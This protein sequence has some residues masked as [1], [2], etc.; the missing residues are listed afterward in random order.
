MDKFLEVSLEQILV[1]FLR[2][3]SADECLEKSLV[4]FLQESVE[5]AALIARKSYAEISKENSD[6]IPSDSFAKFQC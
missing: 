3:Y 6:E 1:E 2:K 4:K 5:E